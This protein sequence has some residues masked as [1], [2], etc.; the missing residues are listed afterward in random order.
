MQGF[1]EPQPTESRLRVAFM[2]DAVSFGFPA[3]AT[4]AEVANWVESVAQIHD[5]AVV[6]INITMPTYMNQVVKQIG[7]S[8]GTH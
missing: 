2:D 8:H 6:A 3:S 5:S 4:L 7:V 1:H